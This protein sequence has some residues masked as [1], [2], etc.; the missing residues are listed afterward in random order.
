MVLIFAGQDMIKQ[1]AKTKRMLESR[2]PIGSIK[3]T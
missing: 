3:T 1:E 2:N